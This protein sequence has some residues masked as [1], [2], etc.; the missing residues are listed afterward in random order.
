MKPA[1]YL[2]MIGKEK[3]YFHV[4]KHRKK[5]LYRFLMFI[6]GGNIVAGH[7]KYSE[8]YLAFNEKVIEIGYTFSNENDFAEWLYEKGIFT[9]K[10]SSQKFAYFDIH[11]YNMTLNKFKKFRDTIRVSESLRR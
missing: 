11:D 2:Q 1:Y 9:H 3:S 4:I 7:A 5:A 6:G 10:G 8:L